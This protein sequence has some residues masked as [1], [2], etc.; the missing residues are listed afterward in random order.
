MN[1]NLHRR[2]FR[3]RHSDPRSSATKNRHD[4]FIHLGHA[5]PS[6]TARQRA[7]GAGTAKLCREPLPMTRMTIGTGPLARTPYPGWFS[8]QKSPSIL[9]PPADL[10]S[11]LCL[12]TPP[13]ERHLSFPSGWTETGA[14]QATRREDSRVGNR[15]LYTIGCPT[16]CDGIRLIGRTSAESH[17][18]EGPGCSR[19][20]MRVVAV[21]LTEVA[22]QTGAGSLPERRR[23]ERPGSQRESTPVEIFGKLL[24]ACRDVSNTR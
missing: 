22:P 8:A 19:R 20:S 21:S 18:E 5:L 11:I 7:W 14:R 3:G 12:F 16:W 23:R 6:V 24:T 4:S 10:L 1:A 17:I 2:V 15:M 13:S 9:S